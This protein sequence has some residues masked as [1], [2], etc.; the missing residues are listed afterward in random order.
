MKHKIQGRIPDLD[1]Y[2]TFVNNLKLDPEVKNSY[3]SKIKA[4]I[5]EETADA[6]AKTEKE[7]NQIIDEVAEILIERK[8]NEI[9]ENKLRNRGTEPEEP[10]TPEEPKGPDD[11]TPPSG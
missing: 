2:D 7:F 5:E 3:K 4:Q 10:T 8:A 11:K 6:K 1:L 9:A